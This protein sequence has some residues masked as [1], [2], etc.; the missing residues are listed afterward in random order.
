MERGT[1]TLFNAFKTAGA[2]FLVSANLAYAQQEDSVNDNELDTAAL[3]QTDEEPGEPDFLKPPGICEFAENNTAEHAREIAL[4]DENFSA[5][6]NWIEDP[7]AESILNYRLCTDDTLGYPGDSITEDVIQRLLQQADSHTWIQPI[8]TLFF[9]ANP[10]LFWRFD[11]SLHHYF[12]QVSWMSGEN[13]YFPMSGAIAAGYP[14]TLDSTFTIRYSPQL[15]LSVAQDPI[16]AENVLNNEHS[17]E[18]LDEYNEIVLAAGRANPS[19]YITK[20]HLFSE[21]EDF[22]I[23][24]DIGQILLDVADHPRTATSLIYAYRSYAHLKEAEQILSKAIETNPLSYLS[25][26]AN[27]APTY[28]TDNPELFPTKQALLKKTGDE[29]LFKLFKYYDYIKD[30]PYSFELMQEAVSINPL[31]F[32][33]PRFRKS[34][35]EELLA[36]TSTLI[37]DP[38]LILAQKDNP[39][40]TY[41][42]S[43]SYEHYAHLD[44]ADKILRAGINAHPAK[45]LSI[46]NANDG[47]KTKSGEILLPDVDTLFEMARGTPY[48]SYFNQDPPG[49][50]LMEAYPYYKHL[51]EAEEVIK[52]VIKNNVMAYFMLRNF[53]Q[54]APELHDSSYLPEFDVL[55]EAA[56][57]DPTAFLDNYNFYKD[58][59]RAADLIQTAINASPRFYFSSKENEETPA[60][61]SDYPELTPSAQALM[62]SA[63]KAANNPKNIMLIKYYYQYAHLDEADEILAALIDNHPRKILEPLTNLVQRSA[64]NGEPWRSYF[65]R[66]EHGIGVYKAYAYLAQ[67]HRDEIEKYFDDMASGLTIWS[68][69]SASYFIGLFIFF[70]NGNEE[71]NEDLIAIIEKN[72]LSALELTVADTSAPDLHALSIPLQNRL[73]NAAR[74]ALEPSTCIEYGSRKFDEIFEEFLDPLSWLGNAE[75]FTQQDLKNILSCAGTFDP[76]GTILTIIKDGAHIL[77]RF[78]DTEDID[79]LIRDVVLGSAT[80]FL[81]RTTS[82]ELTA[83]FKA[84]NTVIPYEELL[85]AAKEQLKA[86]FEDENSNF[87]Y[88][89]KESAVNVLNNLHNYSSDIRFALIKDLEPKDIIA[90]STLRDSRYYTSTFNFIM[91]RI[92]SALE[93]E[94]ALSELLFDTGDSKTVYKQKIAAL[95][96][97]ANH[98]GRL[99]D[100]LNML[101]PEQIQKASKIILADL[102]SQSR[103][104]GSRAVYSSATTGLLTHMA[105]AGYA[106]TV[107][108]AL[109]ESF[110]GRDDQKFRNALGAI[111]ALYS[112][113]AETKPSHPFFEKAEEKFFINAMSPYLSTSL[114]REDVFDESGQ[115]YQMMVFYNDEDGHNTFGHFIGDYRADKRWK[116]KNH[117]S[118]IS[119]TRNGVTVFA[120]R[121]EHEQTGNQDILDYVEERG[122]KITGLIHRGHSYHVKKTSSR[123]LN[124]DIQFYWLGSCRSSDVWNYISR[125]PNMQFIYS[126]N[127]GT[128]HINDP[129]LKNINDTLAGGNNVSWVN[130]KENAARLSGYDKRVDSYVFPDGSFEYALR[131]GLNIYDKDPALAREAHDEMLSTIT[132]PAEPEI[133][134]QYGMQPF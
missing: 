27:E 48:T 119:F 57:K 129:I 60:F 68:K 116:Y 96:I 4:N 118:F 117:G 42:L 41:I 83:D 127:I 54:L 91:D 93:E 66:E 1:N 71:F 108:N 87:N 29:D 72:P 21:I 51:D 10:P 56:Q 24:S 97:N 107:E 30:Q 98:Y 16:L 95:I 20:R 92:I 114:R 123:Y 120:N 53:G 109:I 61:I 49:R 126:T 9:E 111:A 45:Y 110:A 132:P 28:L 85:N 11:H 33:H 18:D 115:T 22:I 103:R 82:G 38:S 70:A 101:S 32:L 124:E 88:G 64:S 39:N 13:R 35:P 14:S 44:E 63:K 47:P 106:Q 17:F 134:Y 7:H 36:L 77:E 65:R 78:P 86:F 40:F 59:E 55:N 84:G 90:L 113:N 62:E 79:Q 2:A 43:N 37:N 122:G 81:A 133:T 121:P 46:L 105:N 58:H 67:N 69:S 102:I 3:S 26:L 80:S 19:L 75:G 130:I 128:M 34:M 100:L 99:D 104:S 25:I 23:P 74:K 12:S 73:L 125:A 89:M 76:E 52:T 8:L 112:I 94:P 15:L 5:I 31:V 6:Q 131:L 50:S